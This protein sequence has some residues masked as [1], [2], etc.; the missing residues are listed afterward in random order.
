M[1]AP[2]FADR[3]PRGLE[4][5]L[6]RFRPDEVL[7]FISTGEKTGVLSVTARDIQLQIS[8][9]GGHIVGTRCR[10]RQGENLSGQL[11]VR[12]G[13][14]SPAQLDYALEE[15]RRSLRYLGVVLQDLGYATREQIEE[16]LSVQAQEDIL[17]FLRLTEGPFNFHPTDVHTEPGRVPIHVEHLLLDCLRVLDESS[18]DLPAMGA[19]PEL[20]CDVD[21]LVVSPEADTLSR[22]EKTVLQLIDGQRNVREILDDSR[23]GDM[24]GA[25]V[26]SALCARGYAKLPEKAERKRLRFRFSPTEDFR[27]ALG[28]IAIAAM[29]VAALGARISGDPRGVA[30]FPTEEVRALDLARVEYAL[31]AFR[32]VYGRYPSELRQLVD[33][34]LLP[35]EALPPRLL[36]AGAYRAGEDEYTLRAPQG[37]VRVARLE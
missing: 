3:T 7:Q 1:G 9:K 20:N 29:L 16:V 10:R 13:V 22:Q 34:S 35:E 36:L 33:A 24:V 31:E 2:A 8:F 5:D 30:P 23:L 21:R 26:L 19:V 17:R 15:Q 37:D 12:M 25:Q 6:E 28:L 4:G 11:F 18:G 14:L 32:L 27:H